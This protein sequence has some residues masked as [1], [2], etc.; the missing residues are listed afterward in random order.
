MFDQ[1]GVHDIYRSWSK[2]LASYD[3]DR[4]LIAEACVEPPERV[5]RYLRTGEMQQALNFRYLETRWDA[6]EL[7]D[8]ITESLRANDLVGAP[9]TWVLSNHDVVRHAS[10]LGL[11]HTGRAPEGIGAHDEQ[12][13]ARLGLQRAR[14]V[15]LLTLALPGSAYLFQGEELGLPEHTTLADEL[16]RDPVWLR[17]GK[18]RRGRDGCR[19]PI[20]WSAD[21]A[22]FGFSPTG[23]SW[24]PQPPEWS[25][26]AVD[27]QDGV[28]ASTLELYRRALRIRR[29]HRLGSG[30]LD[31]L[32]PPASLGGDSIAL[33]NGDVLVVVNFAAV[34]LP[35]PAGA[36]VLLASDDL[37]V[38][39]VG[40]ISL[41]TDSAAWLRG[42]SWC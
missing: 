19:V 30:K 9:T 23:K 42:T 26:I 11:T 2:V 3:G 41:A 18:T 13:D 37:V 4:A 12:P 36:E 15:A 31:W 17:S 14:A 21:E 8:A 1:D 28:F 16:R 34:L 10:R 5:A 27:S 39:G 6:R 32:E 20:P 24:L 33:R 22:A 40:G 38:D 7:R 25:R 29:D 35:L